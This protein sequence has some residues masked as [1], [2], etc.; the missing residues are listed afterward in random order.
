MTIA[1]TVNG[2]VAG[3]IFDVDEG[4]DENEGEKVVSLKMNAVATGA[5]TIP[6]EGTVLAEEIFDGNKG[7]SSADL[8]NIT[9]IGDGAF[10]ATTNLKKVVMTKVK[11]IGFQAFIGSGLTELTLPA[12]IE[13][14]GAMAFMNNY[15]LTKVTVL[16]PTPITITLNTF[17]T[18]A[19]N[20]EKRILYVPKGSKAVY[21]SNE[22]WAKNFKEI[23]ELN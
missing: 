12:S 11:K 5:I 2:A 22:N 4:E 8:K 3:D 19:Q 7:I 13:S 21:E 1:V 15:S 9:K 23:R 14:I 6:D 20:R 18:S 16:N 10:K 17:A